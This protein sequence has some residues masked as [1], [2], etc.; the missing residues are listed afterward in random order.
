MQQGFPKRRLAAIRS[1]LHLAYDVRDTM[2]QLQRPLFQKRIVVSPLV[3]GSQFL[4][5]LVDLPFDRVRLSILCGQRG[6]D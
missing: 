3:D 5:E 4:L 6:I 1:E 2:L